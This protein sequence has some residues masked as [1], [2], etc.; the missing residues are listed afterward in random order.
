MPRPFTAIPPCSS[1]VIGCLFDKLK[2]KDI[3]QFSDQGSF[4]DFPG[5][6]SPLVINKKNITQRLVDKVEADVAGNL[7][8]GAVVLDQPVQEHAGVEGIVHAQNHQMGGEIS[9]RQLDVLTIP[10][11][12]AS[13]MIAG[14]KAEAGPGGV[15]V[16]IKELA[17]LKEKAAAEHAALIAGIIRVELTK[18]VISHR[19]GLAGPDKKGF[20]QTFEA[21]PVGKPEK[22][23]RPG[24]QWRRSGQSLDS[25][26]RS[27][28]W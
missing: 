9:R 23:R 15:L 5:C 3:G 18:P 4:N 27:P 28:D 1:P 26:E 21:E 14:L 13:E 10:G 8:D 7:L 11:N 6:G 22:D 25:P 2:V 20:I 16:P 12:G 24:N 17:G 19:N